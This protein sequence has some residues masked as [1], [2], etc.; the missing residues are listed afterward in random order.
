MEKGAF[1]PMEQILHNT[2][3][4]MI[5]QRHQ[6]ELLWSKGLRVFLLSFTHQSRAI[7]YEYRNGQFLTHVLLTPIY[8]FFLNTVDP[9]QLA[10]DKAI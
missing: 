3:K 1:A 4:Y 9:N 7:K 5:F 6:K 10:F 2:F 8:P